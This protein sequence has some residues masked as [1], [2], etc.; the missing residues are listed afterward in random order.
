MAV[1]E[2]L[3]YDATGEFYRPEDR[4]EWD[5]VNRAVEEGQVETAGDSV[6]P[7][8]SDPKVRRAQAALTDLR[9]WMHKSS[10][11]FIDWYSATFPD[12]N[13]DIRLRPFWRNHLS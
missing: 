12:A 13:P 3:Y 11:D 8:A 2:A 9:N 1:T 10:P 6:V 7:C 4:G 5:S